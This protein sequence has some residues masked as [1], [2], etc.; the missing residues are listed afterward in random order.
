M[1]NG[2]MGESVI[3]SQGF[4][5]NVQLALDQNRKEEFMLLDLLREPKA[6]EALNLY[7]NLYHFDV[8]DYNDAM[9]HIIIGLHPCT[10]LQAVG[11]KATVAFNYFSVHINGVLVEVESGK[12]GL[13]HIGKIVGVLRLDDNVLSIICI[14]DRAPRNYFISVT[15]ACGGLLLLNNDD[16][17]EALDFHLEKTALPTPSTTNRSSASS[18]QSASTPGGSSNM[19]RP[20]IPSP[21]LVPLEQHRGDPL[22]HGFRV[23]AAPYNEAD[24]RTQRQR[25]NPMRD[26]GMPAQN[27]L[28]GGTPPLSGDQLILTLTYSYCLLLLLTPTTHGGYL[29]RDYARADRRSEEIIANYNIICTGPETRPID[30][31]CMICLED[32]DTYTNMVTTGC[33]GGH[34]M[35]RE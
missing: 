30:E 12:M 35:H 6:K 26:P 4:Q 29:N 15:M 31:T 16:K 32:F 10:V 1:L 7:Q 9:S 22:E 17:K 28:F 18:G 20:Y 19:E 33:P 2:V 21:A 5:R 24:W 27:G 8:D 14:G 34:L 3:C 11:Q 13:I 23:R 25:H